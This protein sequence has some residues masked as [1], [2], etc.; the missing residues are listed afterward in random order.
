VREKANADP[1]KQTC[2][3]RHARP[4][5]RNEVKGG[6]RAKP[7]KTP[8]QGGSTRDEIIRSI[9]IQDGKRKKKQDGIHKQEDSVIGWGGHK[10]GG[11]P[12]SAPC[13][14]SRIIRGGQGLV[15]AEDQPRKKKLPEKESIAS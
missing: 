4:R 12:N 10:K 9:V 6:K 11:G 2:S 14:C 13:W 8:E 1:I 3:R 5:L 7:Q 15:G